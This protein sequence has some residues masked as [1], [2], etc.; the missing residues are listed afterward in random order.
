[1][2]VNAALRCAAC[3][4]ATTCSE[5]SAARR[6]KEA[7]ARLKDYGGDGAVQQPDKAAAAPPAAL[8]SAVTAFTS[9]EGPPA[10]L[11][12]EVCAALLPLLAANGSLTVRAVEQ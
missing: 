10:F 7:E 3:W 4:R 11:D 5:D 12:P 8:P 1:M 2:C 6:A 9:V